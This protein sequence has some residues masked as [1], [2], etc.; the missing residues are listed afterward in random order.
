MDQLYYIKDAEA[1][2][3][4]EQIQQTLTGGVHFRCVSTTAIADGDQVKNITGTDG[5][6]WPSDEQESGDLFIYNNGTKNLEFIV[7]LDSSGD[8]DV[9]RYSEMGSTGELG[10]LA[11]KDSASGSY[12]PAGTVA[13]IV[14]KPAGS[15]KITTYTP[16]GMIDAITYAPKGQINPVQYKPE[17]SVK[18]NTYTPE[19][20]IGDIQYTPAGS[21]TKPDVD[22]TAPT[23]DF[24]Y[25]NDAEYT[26]YTE[27]LT[28]SFATA[29]FVTGVTA[30][31]ASTP[32]F[33][34]TAATLSTS[35]TGM[36][37]TDIAGT[38]S[39][40][41]VT[42]APAFTG[43]TATLSTSF[44]GTTATDIA[45][46]FTGTTATLSTSFSG[47]TATITVS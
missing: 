26:D 38:F 16:S 10:A 15:V 33:S 30:A 41:S 19:G 45:G 44:H 7:Y 13:D 4:I 12:T 5:S 20:T 35:F 43:T 37:A 28:L 23:S 2:E 31:L 9:F 27:T 34:G 39:G 46:T 40:T 1:Q 3:K 14:Y 25:L 22:V 8:T 32:T 17:G 21:V 18:V 36:T 11:F 24:S 42:I 29:T 47:T 6:S